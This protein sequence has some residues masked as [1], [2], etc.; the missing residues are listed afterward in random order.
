MPWRSG[1]VLV[2]LSAIALVGAVAIAGAGA[3]KE[4]ERQKER[5][6]KMTGGNPDKAVQAIIRYG[7]AACHKIPGAQMPGGLAAPPL[8]DVT[9]RIYLG[10]Q[11]NNTPDNLVRWIV[12]PKQ[13]DPKTGMPVTGIS[14]GEARDIAAY[15]YQQR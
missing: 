12:N 2:L 14:D 8:S 3:L 1:K 13:F 6:V 7:C 9:E 15:L 10:G 4:R 5:A 11:V